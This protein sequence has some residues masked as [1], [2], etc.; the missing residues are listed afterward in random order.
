M[1]IICPTDWPERSNT[2]MVRPYRTTLVSGNSKLNFYDP[3]MM[4]IT[5]RHKIYCLYPNPIREFS[6]RK[7]NYVYPWYPFVSNPFSSLVVGPRAARKA[8]C[9]GWGEGLEPSGK[10]GRAAV[11]ERRRGKGY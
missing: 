9:G 8:K 3:N 11:A 5:I 1:D 4:N 6:S 7:K 2:Q 10:W